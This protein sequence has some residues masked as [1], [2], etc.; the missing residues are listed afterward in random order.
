M[1]RSRTVPVKFQNPS[2]RFLELLIGQRVAE[3][4]D[5]AVKVAK[6]VGDVIECSEPVDCFEFVESY[7]QREYVPW[8]PTQDKRP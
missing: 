2:E 6:P 8:R 3:R 5:R 7:D 4:V 1:V